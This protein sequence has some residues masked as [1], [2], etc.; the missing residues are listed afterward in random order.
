MTSCEQIQKKIAEQSR[1]EANRLRHERR[2]RVDAAKQA[3]FKRFESARRMLA[4]A[5][6]LKYKILMKMVASETD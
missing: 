4:E 6:R 5:E 2:H 3:E 1:L